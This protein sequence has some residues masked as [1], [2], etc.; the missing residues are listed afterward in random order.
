MKVFVRGMTFDPNN[1][2]IVLKLSAE[3][4]KQIGDMDPDSRGLYAQF[5]ETV[6]EATRQLFMAMAEAAM[7]EE[8]PDE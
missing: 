5:H 7:E 6:P 4:R 1:D 8:L 3:E 2:P